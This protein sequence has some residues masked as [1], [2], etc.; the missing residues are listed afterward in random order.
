MHS[1]ENAASTSRRALIGTGVVAGLGAAF[2]GSRPASAAPVDSSELDAQMT[3]IIRNPDSNANE[4]L[5]RSAAIF[6][7][8]DF[9]QSSDGSDFYCWDRALSA[10][11]A[12]GGACVV[13]ASAR[14]YVISRTCSLAGL[15]NVVI[16]G[17]GMGAT[18]ISG[19]LHQRLPVGFSL[20]SGTQGSSNLTIRDMTFRGSLTNDGAL[21]DS[22][23]RDEREFVSNWSATGGVLAS[24][25]AGDRGMQMALDIAGSRLGSGGPTIR[26]LTIERV[27]FV[28]L[29]V[30]PARLYGI[31]GFTRVENC[32]FRRCYD[33]GLRSNESVRIAGNRFEY[34]ADNGVS[35]SRGNT[36]VVCADNVSY[37]SFYNGIWVA[38]WEGEPGP[39]GA[40][41]SGNLVD[42]SGRHGIYVARGSKDVA[43]SGNHIS[44]A[45][46]FRENWEGV[47]ICIEQ[48]DDAS[49]DDVDGDGSTDDER[50][51]ANISVVGNTIV[52][53]ERGGVLIGGNCAN[54]VVVGNTI[55]RPGRPTKPMGGDL[56]LE[57]GGDNFGISTPGTGPNTRNVL[58]AQ[59]LI[60]DDRDGRSAPSA[61]FTTPTANRNEAASLG[62]GVHA[63]LG[64]DSWSSW[65]N[66]VIGASVPH[67]ENALR[68]L[69]NQAVVGYPTAFSPTLTIDKVSG[70]NAV[71]QF[72]TQGA[73]RWIMRSDTTTETG[74]SAGSGLRFEAVGDDGRTRLSYDIRRSDG[75]VTFK[76]VMRVPAASTRPSASESGVGS[77]FYDGVLK[78]PLFSDGSRWRD[79]NGTAV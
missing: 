67:V 40:T 66:I 49:I 14:E 61:G 4:A 34:S 51:T 32:F 33:L 35:I 46:R 52:D 22:L 8:D 16:E 13:R 47:G 26:D 70:G 57:G 39:S 72:A 25:R 11:R 71:L 29:K 48:A 76:T 41:V 60:V 74:D 63:A 3:A 69:G 62:A 7:V 17:A 55:V 44:N 12:F 79:A 30:L 10:A 42:Y 37:G 28:G 54:V 73:P 27:A 75:R 15:N 78:K 43:I 21:G 65:D 5:A 2:I 50:M 53:C 1:P 56:D 68:R 77:I 36:R 31:D 6:Y 45:K 38:G 24:S 23:A 64:S 18:I 20:T 58:V 9:R 59:N 19:M